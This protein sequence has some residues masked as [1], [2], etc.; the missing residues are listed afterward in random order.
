MGQ[1]CH[2]LNGSVVTIVG[3]SYDSFSFEA[4]IV[5]GWEIMLKAGKPIAVA[6]IAI[7]DD[8]C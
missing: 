1:G 2:H 4:H 5:E 7:A 3:D 6:F 8:L